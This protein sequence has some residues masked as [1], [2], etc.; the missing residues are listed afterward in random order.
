[1]RAFSP[2]LS[3]PSRTF[4]SLFICLSVAGVRVL[5]RGSLANLARVYYTTCRFGCYFWN[6]H[7]ALRRDRDAVLSFS[8][9]PRCKK[10]PLKVVKI[11]NFPSRRDESVVTRGDNGRYEASAAEGGT[12]CARVR[13]LRL[14]WI[15]CTLVCDLFS[16]P[17]VTFL[18]SSPERSRAKTARSE[19]GIP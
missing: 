3:R 8:P 16:P 12:G 7:R 9:P 6:R 4:L 11:I 18:F 15:R 19:V 10:D 13:L 14:R 5:S 1:M 2:S 17:S